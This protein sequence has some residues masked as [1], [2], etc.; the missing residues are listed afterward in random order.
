VDAG[1]AVV[2][3]CAPPRQAEVVLTPSCCSLRAGGGGAADRELPYV[4]TIMGRGC[5]RPTIVRV[6]STSRA[7]SGVQD[8][9]CVLSAGL[10]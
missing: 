2:K 8:R 1:T 10:V 9:R 4:A 5:R 6:A 7:P 3:D